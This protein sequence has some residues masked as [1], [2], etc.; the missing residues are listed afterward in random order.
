MRFC[1]TMKMLAAPAF[2][3]LLTGCAI[4]TVADTAVGIATLPVKVAA[5]TVDLATTSQG[6][7]D[8]RR[9][10]EL[11]R[12]DERRGREARLLADRCRAS[13]PLPTDDCR[14]VYAR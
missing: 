9:G 2:A 7:A 5:E 4:G 6:E 3:L 10:R 1:N 13:R 12:E 8:A 11:R 14:T